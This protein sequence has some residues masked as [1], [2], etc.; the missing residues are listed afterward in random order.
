MCSGT[1]S[2]TDPCFT[3]GGG[4]LPFLWQADGIGTCTA[5]MKGTCG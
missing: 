1:G 2:G 4:A 5:P 3:D